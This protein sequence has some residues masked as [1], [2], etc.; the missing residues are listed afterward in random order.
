MTYAF[1]RILRRCSAAPPAGALLLA[2]F[3]V[4]GSACGGAEASPP[5]TPKAAEPGA[6]TPPPEVAS[7]APL[8]GGGGDDVAKGMRALEANDAVTAKSY[9]DHALRTNPKDA[10]ALYY[11]GVLAEKANDKGAAEKDYKSALEAKPGFEEAA[12]N[13]S[14]IYVDG[15]RYDEALAVAQAALA[16]HAD[17]ASLHSNAAIALAGK[18]DQAG[19]SKEFEAS[20]HLSPGEPMYRLTYGHW[21]GVWKQADPALVQL[22]A[23]R[24]IAK[25][26]GDSG[27]DVLAAIGHE[28]H[29]LRAW[30]DCVPAYDDAIALKDA[31]DLRTERAAC[32]I[33]AKD[34]P[35][36]LADLQAAV[37]KD[38]AFAPAHYYLAG[39]L[40]RAG[41]FKEA[42]AE[43]EAFLKLE[44][45]GPRTK[46]AQDKLKLARQ[47]MQGK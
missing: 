14:A 39:E 33:G 12:I 38:P 47:R 34:S 36:A 11:E 2:V 17:N 19:A 21:L 20:I 24:P 46:S 9:F 7:A 44:P 26:L 5:V 42:A 29:L 22:R 27:V 1:S 13:L 8:G 25:K 16:K 40:A 4:G 15:Q 45:T 32:K 3:A 31:A 23:A 41:Q 30:S 28:M 10:S 35:G 18:G 43:Y 37:A 6:P